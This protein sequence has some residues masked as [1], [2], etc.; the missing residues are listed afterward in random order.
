MMD[1]LTD[2][3]LARMRAEHVMIRSQ[4]GL[5][6]CWSCATYPVITKEWPCDAALLLRELDQRNAA[7]RAWQGRNHQ[8]GPVPHL[9]GVAYGLL[10]SATAEE[11][12]T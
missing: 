11:L 12:S 6:I 2:A 8:P 4:E 5:N 7:V 9:A 3:E 10:G 1:R